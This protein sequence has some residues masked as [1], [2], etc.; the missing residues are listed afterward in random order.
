MGALMHGLGAYEPTCT[1]L[2]TPLRAVLSGEHIHNT[3]SQPATL[4]ILSGKTFFSH[5]LGIL[6]ISNICVASI[7]YTYNALFS[8]KY[9]H[10]EKRRACIHVQLLNFTPCSVSNRS[11][12][13]SDH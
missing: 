5:T 8:C 6:K 1:P 4:E 3:W 13:F 9:W 7:N 12:S 10:S 11:Q 2:A